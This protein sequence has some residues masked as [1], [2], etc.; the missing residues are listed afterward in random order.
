M[1]LIRPLKLFIVAPLAALLLAGC[2][3]QELYSKL[4]ERQANEMVAA[5]RAAGINADKKSQEGT[6]SVV[7]AAK[8]F[9]AAVNT[10]KAQ[11]LPREQFDS[12]GKI[13]KR[14]GFVS[15]P[16]EERARMLHAL[17]QE[18]SNTIANIDGVITA[19]VHLAVPERSPLAD[20]AK[21]SGASIFIK[22]RADKDLA[23]QVSQIKAL[24]VNSIEG[25]PYDNVTVALF[26]ADAQPV[27]GV[28]PASTGKIRQV[29]L[30]GVTTAKATTTNQVPL[31]SGAAAGLLVCS[32]GGFLWWR[33]RRT[34]EG[35]GTPAA[36]KGA[37]K[38]STLAKPNG[39]R[40]VPNG[41]ATQDF[42][43]AMSRAAADK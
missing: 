22:H 10:L 25:L 32:S 36:S 9:P 6:F 19:R 7:T 29:S 30:T 33:R 14:E 42:T 26:P 34:P 38:K 40:T 11:G 8:D 37:A 5:L 12:M 1:K 27:E 2:N 43:A 31:I 41:A 17:S 15:S 3:S 16:L 21:P 28:R 20:K 24:V 13:F 18:I 23:S 35:E 39:E 4:S